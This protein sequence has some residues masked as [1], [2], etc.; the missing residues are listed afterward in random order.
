MRASNLVCMAY[1]YAKARYM[2]LLRKD[3]QRPAPALAVRKMTIAALHRYKDRLRAFDAARLELGL[4]SPAE[5]QRENSA[6]GTAIRPRV[7]RFSQH[8]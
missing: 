2:Q 8:A 5:I 4:A 6:V 3:P 1:Q 7:L